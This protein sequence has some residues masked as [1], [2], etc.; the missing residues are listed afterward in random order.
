[1]PLL[2]RGAKGP[3]MPEEN[4]Y[5]N[6]IAL[7]EMRQIV[8]HKYDI[9]GGIYVERAEEEEIVNSDLQRM[10]NIISKESYSDSRIILD[11]CNVFTLAHSKAHDIDLDHYF[12]E[13]IKKLKELDAFILFL[14]ISPETSWQRRKARYDER[15]QEFPYHDRESIMKTYHDYLF[16]FKPLLDELY[17]RIDLPK[18]KIDVNTPLFESLDVVASA[19]EDICGKK[20]IALKKRF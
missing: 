19:F 15:I 4:E 1:M 5:K 12:Q 18:V 17:G 8:V 14:D 13:Y 7:Q 9:P 6:L 16:R 20:K 3:D 10:N 11:E 2:T